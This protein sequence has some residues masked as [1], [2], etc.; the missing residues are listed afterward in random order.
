[1]ISLISSIFIVS[2]SAIISTMYTDTKS[3]WYQCAKPN[4]ILP[5]YAYMYVWLLMYIILMIITFKLFNYRDK[6]TIFSIILILILCSLWSVVYFYYHNANIA[7]GIIIAIWIF[8][9]DLLFSLTVMNK[10][11]SDPVI[12][13]PFIIWI[14]YAVFLNTDSANKDC[15]NL[16]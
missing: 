9:W 3:K 8:S 13:F 16:I 11:M 14:S 10:N 4:S 1:M 6:P 12:L 5:D 2:I 7:L 15:D